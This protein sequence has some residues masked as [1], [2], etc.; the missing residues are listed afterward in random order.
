MIDPI[1]QLAYLTAGALFIVALNW[2]NAPATALKGVYAAVA[3]TAVA[4][5]APSESASR[6]SSKQAGR[7]TTANAVPYSAAIEPKAR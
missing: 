2:M 5:G 1:S 4:T 3:G 7:G 6:A